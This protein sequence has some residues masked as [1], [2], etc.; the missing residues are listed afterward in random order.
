MVEP[1][2]SKVVTFFLFSFFFLKTAIKPTIV[3][4]FD[5]VSVMVEQT[6][7]EPDGIWGYQKYNGILCLQFCSKVLGNAK[8]IGFVEF[9]KSMFV[10]SSCL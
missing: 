10:D 1:W 3:P 8:D 7:V 5:H 9:L 2:F 6:V 4:W